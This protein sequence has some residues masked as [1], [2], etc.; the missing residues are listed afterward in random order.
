MEELLIDGTT[1]PHFAVIDLISDKIS[2]ETTILSF[3]LLEKKNLAEEISRRSRPTS[4]FKPRP[5]FRA[6]LLIPY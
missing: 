3:R 2:N 1:M 4:A 5:C 6:R